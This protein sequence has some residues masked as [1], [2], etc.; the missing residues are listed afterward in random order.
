MQSSIQNRIF[1][2]FSS[3]FFSAFRFTEEN[4]RKLKEKLLSGKSWLQFIFILTSFSSTCS[5]R[6][7]C[8]CMFV[9]KWLAICYRLDFQDL[10]LW[11]RKM[12]KIVY[13]SSLWILRPWNSMWVTPNSD[14]L[15]SSQNRTYFTE[16]WKWIE[17]C[18]SCILHQLTMNSCCCIHFTF[19][20]L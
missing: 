17:N 6:G 20:A 12:L 14:H 13:N 19:L 1:L 7:Q 5:I 9:W 4:E 15:C 16:R 18:S 11:Q 3:F 8:N 10:N 2:V